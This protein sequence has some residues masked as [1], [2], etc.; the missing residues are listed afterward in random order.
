M[1]DVDRL[2]EAVTEPSARGIAAAVGRLISDGSCPTGTRLPTVR[3]VSRRLGLSPTT[4][5]DAWQRLARFGLVEGRGRLGTFVT[6][7][8]RTGGAR[9]YRSMTS[10]AGHVDLDLSTGSPDPLLLPDIVA[11]VGRLPADS[12]ATNYWDRPVLP[13]LEDLLRGRQ[14]FDAQSLTVV[15]GALDA[16]E[17][18]AS[19][20]LVLGDRVIVE[21]PAF[22]PLLDLLDLL[23]VEVIPVG[24]DDEGMDPVEFAAALELHPRAVFLQ[25]RAHNP[26]GR[27]LSGGRAAQLAGLLAGTSTLVV[28]DDHSGDIST[29]ANISLGT[30]LPDRTVRITSFSKS[31]GPDL[32]LAAVAGPHD[33]IDAVVE[34][35]AIGPAWSSRI[36][37]GVLAAL[38]EDPVAVAT[39]ARAREAYSVRRQ[40]LVCALGEHGVEVGGSDGINLWVP[41][42]DERTS[43]VSLAARSIGVAP[44]FPFES[45][46]LPSEHIRVT[47]SMVRED[48]QA[49]AAALAE[50]VQGRRSSGRHQSR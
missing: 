43:T 37:Q 30:W 38:L 34:R 42:D 41:T 40:A 17:R 23:G 47:V 3:E 33:V 21:N 36:L 15:D 50:A 19:W 24:S 29:S 14:P 13:V 2:A 25:P 31:H 11:A 49:V 9:R 48:V 27:S 6:P 18:V 12:M 4:V 10:A 32:R 16:L 26:T 1:F 46:P 45:A 8:T 44:G 22:P 5:S 28:E 39:V 35:R 7:R 20:A